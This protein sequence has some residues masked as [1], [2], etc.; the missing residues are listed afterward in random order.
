MEY[1]FVKD[2]KIP[3]QV[4]IPYGG[5][6]LTGGRLKTLWDNNI[7]FLKRFDLDRM[8][9][10]YRVRVGKPAPGV[11]YGNLGGHFEYGIKGQT[12]GEN[13]VAVFC[14]YISCLYDVRPSADYDGQIL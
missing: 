12:A 13:T 8:L 5:V 3:D 10:W 7:S 1:T 14:D 4:Q 6:K 11:P 9:Y 2:Q